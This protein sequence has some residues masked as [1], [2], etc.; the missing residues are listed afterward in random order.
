[1]ASYE[2]ASLIAWY[3]ARSG[4]RGRVLILDANDSF[5]KQALFEEVWRTLYPGAVQ[6]IPGSQD[7]EVVAV[8]AANLV[9]RTRTQRYQGHL[10]N[11]IPPQ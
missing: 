11:V 3:L 8:D 9:V 2:R 1:M 10:P 4:K 5:P 7:G 6:R